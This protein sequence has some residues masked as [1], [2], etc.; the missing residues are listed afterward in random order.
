MSSANTPET[1]EAKLVIESEFCTSCELC[2][3]VCE[4]DAL[5]KETL[6]NAFGVRPTAWR[7]SCSLCGDCVDACSEQSIFIE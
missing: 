3:A 1:R 4:E 2:F 7:G 5:F 6:Y